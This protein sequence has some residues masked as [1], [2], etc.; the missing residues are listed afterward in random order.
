MKGL[1][2][3]DGYLFWKDQKSL[4][5]LV[6]I[7]CVVAPTFYY[8]MPT[9]IISIIVGS[10]SL[11]SADEKCEWDRLAMMLPYSSRSLVLSKY[12]VVW[13]FLLY[14]LLVYTAGLLLVAKTTVPEAL[15]YLLLAATTSLAAQGICQPILFNNSAE[16]GRPAVAIIAGLVIGAGVGTLSLIETQNPSLLLPFF[17]AMLVGIGVNIGSV[18]L[19]ER[20]YRQRLR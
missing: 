5:F 18:F 1:L 12:I 13:L 14:S 11:L 8:T 16:L 19:S 20:L 2:Y 6:G 15:V 9:I 3:K 10:I 7:F 4:F 17:I